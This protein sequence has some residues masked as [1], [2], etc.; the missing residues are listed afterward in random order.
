MGILDTIVNYLNSIPTPGNFLKNRMRPPGSVNEEDFLRLCVRCARCVEA[1]PYKVLRRSSAT[2]NGEIGTPYI[3]AEKAG[4]QLCLKCTTVC[5]TG[6]IDRKSVETVEQV[7]IGIARIDEATCMNYRYDRMDRGLEE[8]DGMIAICG[9][10]LNNCPLREEA[11]YLKGGLLPTI[12][13]KCTGC[14]LCVERCPVKPKAISII[15]KGMPDS[16]TAGYYNFLKRLDKEI[17]EKQSSKKK[18]G[19]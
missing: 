7:A 19:K 11:I 1:C 5:P 9:T 18:E 10:C 12:T 16:E 2:K 6:A 8:N 3:Y 14:G 17:E 15:P 13:E 4:C